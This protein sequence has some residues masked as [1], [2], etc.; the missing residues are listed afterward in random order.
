MTSLA[1]SGWNNAIEVRQQCRSGQRWEG[2]R[3]ENSTDIG[4][5]VGLT[6]NSVWEPTHFSYNTDMPNTKFSWTCCSWW[7]VVLS[8]NGIWVSYS[9]AIPNKIALPLYQF[10][11]QG[12][13]S[14]LRCHPTS[15]APWPR[16]INR[17]IFLAHCVVLLY[18]FKTLLNKK[19]YTPI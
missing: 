12:T 14:V 18:V 10:G 17:Y 13:D 1:K 3:W 7:K 11:S 5:N 4:P 15:E 8:A 2:Q 9:I 16:F 6:H 19:L